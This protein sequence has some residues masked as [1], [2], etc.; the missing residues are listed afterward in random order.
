LRVYNLFVSIMKYLWNMAWPFEL[1]IFYPFPKSIPVAH[2][3]LALAS[4]S[5][6]TIMT[7][8]FRKSRP[9]LAAGWFWFL[10]ALAPASGLIQAGLWPEMANR[11]IYIPMI[12]LFL[13][14]VWEG[15]ERIT[16]HYSKTL[17]VIL[18][19]V[20][21][22]YFIP[23]TKT[24]NHYFSNSYALFARAA[25]VTKD[26]VIAYNN[27]GDALASLNRE[28]EAAEYFKKAIALNPK[29]AS[30]LYNYGV[31]LAKR[32]DYSNAGSYYSRAMA[33]NPRHAPAYGNLGMI[34]YQMGDIEAAKKLIAN[35]LDIDPDNGNARNNLGTILAAQDKT[36]EAIRYFLIALEKKPNFILARLNL[37]AAYERIG[38]YEEAV[39]EYEILNKNKQIDKG[40]NYYRMAGVRSKQKR[41][42]EC[43]NYL[44]SSLRHGFDVTTHLK[45]DERFVAFRKTAI[46]T[47]FLENREVKRH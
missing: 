14:L 20:M 43:K 15:D 3:L 40:I 34:Q 47:Q 26:N 42:E 30:A 2:F 35:A 7:I 12:G 28:D 9:W 1:S 5:V 41:F 24:Q 38:R 13:I 11:F 10:V 21:L 4:L 25:S 6:I 27:I 32:G 44:D 31:Y 17:K 23:L 29:Y 45:S 19:C 8:M 33:I 22:L 39:A 36:E 16:G 18:C 37:S 46:Y